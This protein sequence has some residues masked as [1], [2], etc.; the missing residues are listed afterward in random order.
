MKESAGENRN[1]PDLS[2]R[3]FLKAAVVTAIGTGL[4]LKALKS[5]SATE[6]NSAV[7]KQ[8]MSKERLEELK[9]RNTTIDLEKKILRSLGPE[10]IK[11]IGTGIIPDNVYAWSRKYRESVAKSSLT[12]VGTAVATAA[13]HHFVKENDEG[14]KNVERGMSIPFGTAATA[15]VGLGAAT[16]LGKDALFGKLT[17]KIIK[18]AEDDVVAW[19]QN[20]NVNKTTKD[21]VEDGIAKQINKLDRKLQGNI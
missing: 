1:E 19:I 4:G 5:Q 17:P 20:Y 11:Q 16:Y 10:D 14:K 18:D 7:D 3:K 2:R 6:G 13:V 12:A 9:E 21:T 8:S 15:V